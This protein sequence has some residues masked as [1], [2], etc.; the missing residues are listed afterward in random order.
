MTKGKEGIFEEMSG[1]LKRI[2]VDEEVKRILK[3]NYE[4]KEIFPVFHLRES[5]ELKKKCGDNAAILELY[6]RLNAL[7]YR[8]FNS[9]DV[10]RV[11]TT[12]FVSENQLDLWSSS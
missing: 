5:Q 9:F 3:E 10:H 4:L 8:N 7:K 11:V 1:Y 6:Y 2:G 12:F